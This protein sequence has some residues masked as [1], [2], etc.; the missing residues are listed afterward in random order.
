MVGSA[1]AALEIC[2]K[3]EAESKMVR[4]RLNVVAT[5]FIFTAQSRRGLED[6]GGGEQPRC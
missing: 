4:S 1:G 6:H 3:A 5:A 2:H